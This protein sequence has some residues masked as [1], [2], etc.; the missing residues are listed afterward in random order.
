MSKHGDTNRELDEGV[1]QHKNDLS[2]Y[3]NDNISAQGKAPSRRFSRRPTKLDDDSGP[4]DEP[5]SQFSGGLS[6]NTGGKK[7]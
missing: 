3:S 6:F 4:P 5:S 1:K 2:N 7:T